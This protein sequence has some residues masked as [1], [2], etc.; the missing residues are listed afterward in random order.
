[1][2]KGWVHPLQEELG[3]EVGSE[4]EGQERQEGPLSRQVQEQAGK[5][6]LRGKKTKEKRNKNIPLI[7]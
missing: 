2:G 3:T 1:M 4:R 5:G 7:L 6:M